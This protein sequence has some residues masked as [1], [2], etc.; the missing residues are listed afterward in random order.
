MIL[1]KRINFCLPLLEFTIDIACDSAVYR[2]TRIFLS[3]LYSMSSTFK[4]L[5]IIEYGVRAY[6]DLPAVEE[7]LASPITSRLKPIDKDYQQPYSRG[8][9]SSL[10]RQ[11]AIHVQLRPGVVLSGVLWDVHY[12]AWLFLNI[13]VSV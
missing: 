13:W 2:K 3:P 11:E 9:G 12:P 4:A 8:V 6:Q 1:S 10:L 5:R 7:I